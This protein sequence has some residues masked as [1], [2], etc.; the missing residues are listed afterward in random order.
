VSEAERDMDINCSSTKNTDECLIQK[1]EE[2]THKEEEYT[3]CKHS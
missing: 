3:P 2:E 1:E